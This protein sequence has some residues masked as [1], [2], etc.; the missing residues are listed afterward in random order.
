MDGFTLCLE[1]GKQPPAL[2]TPRN[3][4]QKSN[5]PIISKANL[6]V[7]PKHTR[8]NIRMPPTKLTQYVVV[9]FFGL[10]WR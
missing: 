1:E 7:G 9:E 10:R 6:H 3:F 2:R 8:R 4:Q 5:R